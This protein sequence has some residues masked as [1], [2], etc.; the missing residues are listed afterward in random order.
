MN[1]KLKPDAARI[2]AECARGTPRVANRYLRRIRDV[3]HSQNE[4]I[5][6]KNMARKGLKMLGVDHNGLCEMDRR[7]LKAIGEKG[8]NAIGLKTLAVIAGEQ[9]ETIEEVYEPYLIRKGLLE[10]T[11][12]GRTLT[13]RGREYIGM[14]IIEQP[15]R[16]SGSSLF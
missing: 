9:E 8:G 12:R 5:I 10:K 13:E 6:G 7:I 1:V 15:D 3:A 14:E 4:A 16:K 11:P 2:M